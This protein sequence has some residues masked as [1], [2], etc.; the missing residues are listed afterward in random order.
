MLRGL[1]HQFPAEDRPFPPED[2]GEELERAFFW[3]RVVCDAITHKAAR[4][5]RSRSLASEVDNV[6]R[7]ALEP[8]VPSDEFKQQVEK[9]LAEQCYHNLLPTAEKSIEQALT[10]REVLLARFP[11]HLRPEFRDQEDVKLLTVGLSKGMILWPKL[12]PIFKTCVKSNDINDS[13]SS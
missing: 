11:R 1:A 12:E 10:L 9:S 4:P 7:F 8:G 5:D 2:K 13:A 3:L 6:F